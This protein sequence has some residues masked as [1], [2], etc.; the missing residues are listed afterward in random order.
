MI[1][2]SVSSFMTIDLIV[3]KKDMDVSTL[4]R[5]AKTRFQQQNLQNIPALVKEVQVVSN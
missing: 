5:S 4:T 3:C 1:F 2:T